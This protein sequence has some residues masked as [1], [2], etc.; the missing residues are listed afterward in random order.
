MALSE[1]VKAKADLT[2]IEANK[3]FHNTQT[4]FDWDT[5]KEHTAKMSMF[6]KRQLRFEYVTFD[7]WLNPGDLD[8]ATYEASLR[9]AIET[10]PE[11]RVPM[12]RLAYKRVVTHSVEAASA[13]VRCAK[14]ALELNKK[15]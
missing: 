10:D 15:S 9:E 7:H 14:Y 4:A 2:V 8:I 3:A 12:A 11:V 1:N 6:R 13:I 5:Y